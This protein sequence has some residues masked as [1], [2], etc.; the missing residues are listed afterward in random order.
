[1]MRQAGQTFNPYRLFY[2]VWIPEGLLRYQGLSPGA[3]LCYGRLTRYAGDRGKCWPTQYELA[4]ELGV[5]VRNVRRYLQELQSEFFIRA[6]QRGLNRSNEYE[7][8]WHKTFEG[9]ERTNP[10]A[11]NGPESSS[12]ER[13]RSASPSRRESFS[14][15]ESATTAESAAR[16]VF[17]VA[18]RSKRGLS[19]IQPDDA[20]EIYEKLR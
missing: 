1:M 11:P 3:K 8:L 15:V 13:P 9:S 20:K 16:P 2:G 4:R 17:A 14:S 18:S 12:L 19:R 5:S 6:T 10:S 7:F